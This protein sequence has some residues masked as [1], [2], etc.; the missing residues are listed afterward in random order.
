[1]S[2]TGVMRE[3]NPSQDKGKAK[4]PDEAPDVEVRKEDQEMINEFGRLNNQYLELDE[5]LA[6]LKVCYQCLS[7]HRRLCACYP[8]QVPLS[9]VIHP[10]PKELGLNTVHP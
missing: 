3:V 6:Y 4:T 5:D 2:T 10:P 8:C 7:A 1:M 9:R